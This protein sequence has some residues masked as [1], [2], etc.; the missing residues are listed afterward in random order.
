MVKKI[1]VTGGCGFI[2]HHFVEHVLKVTDWDVVVL[3]KL[4]YA[5]KGFDRLRDIDA[6]DDKRVTV[7]TSDITKSFSSGLIKEIGNIDYLIHMAAETH[8]D[9]SITDPEPFVMSNVL[10]TM[11]VLNYAR[12]VKSLER[13][14]YF[15][16]DEVFG[17]APEGT[18]Y[19]EWDAYNSSNPYAATKAAGEELCLAY[20]NTYSLP[21]TITHTMNVFGERQHPEKFIPLVTRS[22][23][24]EEKVAI[25]ANP[26]CTKAGTRFYIHARNV[27]GAVLFLLHH[28]FPKAKY[29]IVGE[30]ELDNLE[31]AQAIASIIGKPLIYELV[32]FHS[33]RPGHD[34]RYA[35]D[36]QKMALLGWQPKASFDESL[37]K[38]I[39]WMLANP[40]WLSLK[41][42]MQQ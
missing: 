9:N 31:L 23:L 22:I 7:L 42:E 10:G 26:G 39:Q 2:G 41:D 37:K 20:A 33:S 38:T 5:S 35:L 24:Q 4:T 11:H 30:R 27:A 13:M 19:K 16:T 25:H 18:N 6:F 3:D 15:S 14:I 1:L 32:N 8:V 34:L 29:N 40:S 12:R 17:P 21:I 28:G 36:G